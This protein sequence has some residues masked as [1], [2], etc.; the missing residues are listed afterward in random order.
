M[1]EKNKRWVEKRY[2]NWVATLPCASCGLDD[3]TTVAHHLKHRHSP[4][5]GA[6]IGMK[7]NDFL[8]MPLCFSCHDR[9]HNGDAD[10]LD[11]QADHIFKTLTT[12]FNSG[13]IGYVGE[14]SVL[15]LFLQKGTLPNQPGTNKE[16]RKTKLFGEDLDD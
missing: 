4:H 14:G 3:E 5:G 13:I 16:W 7:A 12:A 2:T 11:W 10:V 8:T 15:E 1:I 6:G 9:A